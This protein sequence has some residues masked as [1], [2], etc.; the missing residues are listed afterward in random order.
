MPAFKGTQSQYLYAHLL[1]VFERMTAI[2]TSGQARL[3]NEPISGMFESD[4]N[5]YEGMAAKDANIDLV[6]QTLQLF[7]FSYFAGIFGFPLVAGWMIIET[8][9]TVLL[10]LIAILA[11]IEASLA[12]RRTL[13]IDQARKFSP[14]KLR[15]H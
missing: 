9:S 7:A 13:A 15:F 6:A 14:G 8:G 3:G 4:K 5:I 12:L 1:P 10:I 2:S 11:A